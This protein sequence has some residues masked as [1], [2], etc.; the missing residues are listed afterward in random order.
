MKQIGKCNKNLSQWQNIKFKLKFHNQTFRNTKNP[1]KTALSRPSTMLPRAS[2]VVIHDLS[3]CFS[4]IF[5]SRSLPIT[6]FN[7][8]RAWAPIGNL[9]RI[10]CILANLCTQINTIRESKL[11]PD[12]FFSI[13]T[14][15]YFSAMI[16][17]QKICG[18]W[19]SR[20]AL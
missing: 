2:S 15:F 16:L 11:F 5:H 3:I 7:A 4:H 13:W 10:L 8:S 18:R 19:N 14:N 12:W 9:F 17:E 6:L 20:D 1:Q